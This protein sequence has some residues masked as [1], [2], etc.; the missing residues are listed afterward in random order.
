MC[1]KILAIELYSFSEILINKISVSTI[2]LK[3]N[4]SHVQNGTVV[5]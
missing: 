2:N 3:A 5:R 1:D 4:K